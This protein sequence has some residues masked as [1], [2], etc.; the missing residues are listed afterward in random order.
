MRRILY[1]L[2]VLALGL[3]LVLAILVWR[4]LRAS[5]TVAATPT[6]RT[7]PAMETVQ[8]GAYLAQ[9]GNCALCHTTPGGEPY[10]G[11]KGVPTPFGTVYTSNLT[12][13]PQTGLGA[14]DAE[15]FWRAMH[16]GRSRDGHLLYPAFP[17]T[18]FTQL[19][20]D[21]SDALFAYLQTLTPADTPN[22][23]HTLRWPYGTQWALACLLY[24][25]PSPRD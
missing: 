13:H 19:A 23:V 18:S 14:W 22:R 24:T 8:R 16:E 1:L 20:R 17:Y 12:P 11:G 10:A 7:A 21:D 25:S 9:V 3:G 2:T 15:D 4:E 6:S 5:P